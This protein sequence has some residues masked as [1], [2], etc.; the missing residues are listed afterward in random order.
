MMHS[1]K[2]MQTD[3][4]HSRIA[5]VGMFCDAML[6]EALGSRRSWKPAFPVP[7]LC[8]LISSKPVCGTRKELNSN[9]QVEMRFLHANVRAWST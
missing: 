8:M 4:S 6:H 3:P 5:D 9:K 2:T 7:F 1:D